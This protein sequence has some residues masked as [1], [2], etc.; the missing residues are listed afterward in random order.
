MPDDRQ[1]GVADGDDRTFLAAA[2]GEAAV[3]VT[4]KVSVRDSAATV[5]PR[6]AASHGLSL[7]V[8]LVI[9]RPA[10]RES[11]GAN[12]AHETRCAAVGKAPISS[13]ASAMSSSAD[14][15]PTPGI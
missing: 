14:R 4:Q 11:M 13:P 3:A 2:A 9:L 15:V 5:S 8:V 12:F 6:V 10:D 1:D 7:P